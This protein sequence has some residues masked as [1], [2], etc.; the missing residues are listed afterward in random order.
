MGR[1]ENCTLPG[2]GNKGSGSSGGDISTN[3]YVIVVD[4][5]VINDEVS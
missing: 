1:V 2:V 4:W 5:N 3:R